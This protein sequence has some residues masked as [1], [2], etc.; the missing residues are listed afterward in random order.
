M[1]RLSYRSSMFPSCGQ[2]PRG[3]PYDDIRAWFRHWTPSLRAADKRSTRVMPPG[4]SPLR[5]S[6]GRINEPNDA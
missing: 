5:I 1:I 4:D 6:S 3:D 2:I